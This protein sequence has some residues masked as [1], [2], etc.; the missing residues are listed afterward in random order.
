MV[1]TVLSIPPSLSPT[2]HA[3]AVEVGPEFIE[4]PAAYST[5][6]R[7]AGWDLID[8]ADVTAQ[9]EAT[10][11]RDLREWEIRAD[12]LSELLGVAEF[13]E[14]LTWRRARCRAIADGLLQRE[15]FIATTLA[16]HR[17][18]PAPGSRSSLAQEG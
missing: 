2:E 12:K 6:L 1:F 3:K 9:Y 13:D 5:L 18:G 17:P 15:L 11:G 8:C 16:R 14:R 7:E 4:A 10:A